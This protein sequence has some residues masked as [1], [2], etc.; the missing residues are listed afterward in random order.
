[1]TL[2][3][4]VGEPKITAS[5][6]TMSSPV[7]SGMSAVASAC[8]AHAGLDSMAARGASSVARRNRTSAPARSAL[9]AISFA[10][11]W[12]VPVDE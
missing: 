3:Y 4:R 5:A 11:A 1:M 7:A 6:Q 9:S 2:P 10:S 12:T 8:A